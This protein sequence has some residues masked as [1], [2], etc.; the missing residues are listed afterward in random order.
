MPRYI[1]L[2]TADSYRR[3]Y[4]VLQSYCE[5]WTYI[6]S[7]SIYVAA[8]PAGSV[9]CRRKPFTVGSQTG[10]SGGAVCGDT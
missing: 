9:A 1:R 2:F 8:T 6:N 10:Q 7:H 5:D 3:F 4:V